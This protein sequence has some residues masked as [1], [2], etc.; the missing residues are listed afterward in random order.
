MPE[1]Q[2]QMYQEGMDSLTALV[3]TIIFMALIVGGA[4][5]RDYYSSHQSGT[6]I[7]VNKDAHARNPMNGSPQNSDNHR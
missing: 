5:V 4:K 6:E 2:T 3:I 7:A 1:K